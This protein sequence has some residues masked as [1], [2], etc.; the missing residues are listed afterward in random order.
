MTC[1][2][3]LFGEVIFGMRERQTHRRLDSARDAAVNTA[4]TRLSCD[5][6][7]E[8]DSYESTGIIMKCIDD[9]YKIGRIMIL[10]LCQNLRLVLL[11]HGFPFPVNTDVGFDFC[12]IYVRLST[13]SESFSA[14]PDL[15]WCLFFKLNKWGKRFSHFREMKSQRAQK[16]LGMRKRF[17]CDKSCNLFRIPIS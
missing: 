7:K 1:Q 10:N 14:F 9:S 4:E 6:L 13:L 2:S 12:G 16:Y 15:F 5:S 8:Y 11:F 3:P 17:L